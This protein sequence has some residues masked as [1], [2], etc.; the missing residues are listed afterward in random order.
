MATRKA[1]PKTKPGRSSLLGPG[2]HP[3]LGPGEKPAGYPSSRAGCAALK[4][5]AGETPAAY[6]DRLHR[7]EAATLDRA[8]GA[9]QCGCGRPWPTVY[10]AAD[11]DVRL[12]CGDC[13]KSVVVAGSTWPGWPSPKPRRRSRAR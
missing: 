5:K 11:H 7:E 4:G 3:A 8:V 10:I 12:T 13:S 1:K 2:Y 9:S 6:L